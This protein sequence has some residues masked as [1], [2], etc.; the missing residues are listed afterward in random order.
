MLKDTDKVEINTRML[1]LTIEKLYR[2]KRKV[3]L[4]ACHFSL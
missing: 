1:S 3:S 4:G 2:E